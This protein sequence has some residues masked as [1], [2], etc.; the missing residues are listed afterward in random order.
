MRFL[1]IADTHLGYEA[2]YTSKARKFVFE[3]MFK[4]FENVLDIARNEN[5]DYVL[6]GG[7][8]FN[9]SNPSRKV[10]TRTYQILENLLK[11]DIGF[12]IA[13]GNH[14]RSTLPITLL[15]YHPK[16]YFFTKLTLV[17]LNDCY[18][19]GFPYQKEI[20]K[21]FLN[22]LS[23]LCK[24]CVGKPLLILCHQLFDGVMFGPKRF[25]FG[26]QHGAIDPLPL[27]NNIH[28]IISGHIHRSQKLLNDL[29]LY[30]G[31]IERTSF[32]E[33]IEPKGFIMIEVNP[34]KVNAQFNALETL[35]MEVIEINLLK[36]KFDIATIKNSILKG[37]TRT[38]LRFTGRSIFTKEIKLL[39]NTFPISDYPL[40]TINPRYPQ[41]T[42]L[43]LYE[44]NLLPFNNPSIS[45]TLKIETKMT[46]N[47][48]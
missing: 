23:D 15:H 16:S 12:I 27:P 20:T 41:Q 36:E 3:H 32:V 17:D 25:R 28:L 8:L 21:S 33:A 24:Q 4:V 5:V 26:L 2:G 9:R 6:H 7:D 14:E 29:I 42:L 38:L 44:E 18:L 35:Q 13:P 31:S 46:D 45:K 43:P 19:I 34:E 10:I 22:D 30:P 1:A 11:D 39:K 47:I 37:Y 40:L 48:I